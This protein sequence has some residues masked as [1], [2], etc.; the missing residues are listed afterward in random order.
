MIKYINLL[1]AS[2]EMY[3]NTYNEMLKNNSNE[4]S[5]K[6]IND[7]IIAISNNLEYYENNDKMFI[8][9]VNKKNIS[10]KENINDNNLLPITQNRFHV[11]F[12]NDI[13]LKSED[14]LS[15]YDESYDNSNKMLTITLREFE[16]D[17]FCMPY[18]LRKMINDGTTFN[19]NVE[20]LKPNLD[21]HYIIKYEYVKIIDCTET[22]KTYENDEINKFIIKVN[23][24]FIK[25]ET[26]Y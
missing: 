9:E 3:K 26:T 2:L 18:Y 16:R 13:E 1:K 19:I 10:H 14:V 21:I 24:G 17:N 15:L 4:E 23:Y 25:Y 20:I 5:L 22:I 7:E 6:E 8:K 11:K 12:S